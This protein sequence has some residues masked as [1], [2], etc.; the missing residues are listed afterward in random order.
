[1]LQI[2]ILAAGKGRRMHSQIPKVLHR[3]AGKPLLEHVI[4]TATQLCPD[5]LSVVYGHPQVPE[6]LTHL[7]NKVQ[8]IPQ[9]P[10]LGTGHAAV[11]ATPHLQ[12]ESQV[13][14]LLGDTPLISV[15]TLQ[16]F[17]QQTNPQALGVMTAYTQHPK[18]Y[19]RILRNAH[20]QVTGI[21]EAQDATPEQ[22]QITEI[23]AGIYLASAQA[24]KRWLPQ[25]NTSN[26]QGEYY[27]TDIVKLAAAEGTPISP[28]VLQSL[29]EIQGINTRYQLAQLESNYQHHQANRLLRRGLGLRDCNHFCLR[30]TLEFGQ[31]VTID[32]HVLLEGNIQLGDNVN[33]GP[34]TLLRNVKIASN[35]TIKS[36]CVIED[37]VIESG[38][39][40]GPFARLRPHTHLQAN[41]RIGNFVETKNSEIGTS[42]RV[43]H[44]SYIGDATIGQY[45]NIGAG[46]ITCNFDGYQK[47]RTQIE[48]HVSV[49]AHTALVAPITLRYGATIGAGSTLTHEAPANSLTLSR[50]KQRSLKYQQ[51]SKQPP[52]TEI[53]SDELPGK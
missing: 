16:A 48:D 44:H 50:V 43:N 31:D 53:I 46:V 45:V 14:I 6:Q 34:F 36:H 27:L 1:M 26:A 33:I 39:V 19:G 22:N 4:S 38:C 40:V 47:H 20:Q 25:L 5:T 52:S 49:G 24:L 11:Q 32:S 21:I 35:V 13:L 42:S 30:G 10:A 3:L 23:N 37:S 18:R 8:W 28:F 41:V 12:D 51:R 17:I 2:I 7:N 9:T 29:K 15:D